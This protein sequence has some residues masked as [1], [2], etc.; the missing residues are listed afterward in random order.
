[1]IQVKVGDLIPLTLQV[2]DKRTDLTVTAK[3]VDN[4]GVLIAEKEL[5]SFGDGLYMSQTIQ[6]PDVKFII[7]QYFVTPDEYE[8]SSDQFFAIPKPS[9][10]EKLI[11]G[12]VQSRIKSN[13]YAIGVI[14][15][16]A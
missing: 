6:M 9:E 3:L 10:P 1:M 8:V 11:V 15:N 2:Y 7:A 12:E 5:A 4:F 13:E 14:T 16:E